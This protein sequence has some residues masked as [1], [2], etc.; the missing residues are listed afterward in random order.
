MTYTLKFINKNWPEHSKTSC[1]DQN[2]Y[3]ATV[4]GACFR[5]TALEFRDLELMRLDLPLETVDE[6][7]EE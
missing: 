7:E 5:C 4:E 3:N 6:D 1:D 2:R